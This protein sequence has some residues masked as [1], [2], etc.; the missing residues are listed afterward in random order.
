MYVTWALKLIRSMNPR[1]KIVF[2]FL[3]KKNEA[4]FLFSEQ[5]RRISKFKVEHYVT[6][7][8]E[9]RIFTDLTHNKALSVFRLRHFETFRSIDTT[10]VYLAHVL[11]HV[12]KYMHFFLFSFV[13][14][15][16]VGDDA[17][18]AILI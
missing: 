9:I 8:N 3:K 15:A 5:Q 7:M 13:V 11:V 6:K 16:V 12:L 2:F 18:A 4:D 17:V 14:V 10:E 1:L